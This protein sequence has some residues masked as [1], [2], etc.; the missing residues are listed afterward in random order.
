MTGQQLEEGTEASL[1]LERGRRRLQWAAEG[2]RRGWGPQP[3]VEWDFRLG[4]MGAGRGL[5][6]FGAKSGRLS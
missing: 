1:A 4:A 5:G 6:K 2:D 3:S